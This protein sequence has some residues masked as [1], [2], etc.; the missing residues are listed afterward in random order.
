MIKYFMICSLPFLL[1][2]EF[3]LPPN[4]L[5]MLHGFQCW[6]IFYICRL[7]SL[8]PLLLSKLLLK[9][10]WAHQRMD[11]RLVGLWHHTVTV[12]SLLW[13]ALENRLVGEKVFNF[14]LSLIQ[15]LFEVKKFVHQ[16]RTRKTRN[17]EVI[18]WTSNVILFN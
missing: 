9:L 3:I 18:N 14:S 11:G 17:T 10:P 2:L 12:L 13:M 5:Y 16:T 4:V 15:N 8:H 6:S 1:F 7:T